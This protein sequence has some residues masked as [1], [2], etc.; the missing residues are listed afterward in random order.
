MYGVCFAR[1][2]S[3]TTCAKT[4]KGDVRERERERERQRDR[5][6]QTETD[7]DRQTE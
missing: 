6:R 1:I 5:Q 7:R 4:D 3:E 2:P